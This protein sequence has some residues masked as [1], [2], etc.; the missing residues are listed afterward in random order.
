MNEIFMDVVTWLW[1]IAGLMLIATELF[2]PGLIVCFLGFGA[3]IVA[4]LRW[5]GLFT[6]L[7]QSFIAWVVTSIALLIGLRHFL[8]KWVPSESTY[9]STDEDFDAVGSVVEV[10]QEVSESKQGRIR[11][12][13]TTWPATTRRGVLLPGT[14][15]KLLYRDNLVWVIEPH[16]ELPTSEK[17]S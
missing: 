10:V 9:S 13:G 8:L 7:A 14:K 12:A 11:Y 6:G 1:F 2:I 4:I 15:A 16:Q 5:F 17:E 3:V